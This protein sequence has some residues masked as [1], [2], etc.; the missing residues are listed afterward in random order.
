MDPATTNDDKRYAG[1]PEVVLEVLLLLLLVVPPFVV[2][3]V[4]DEA[5]ERVDA[6]LE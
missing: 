2:D 5:W 6:A 3:E 1:M 4:V